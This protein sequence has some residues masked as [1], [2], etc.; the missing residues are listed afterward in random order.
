MSEAQDYRFIGQ[1]TIRPDGFDKVTGRASYGADL[2]LPGMIWGKVLRSPHAHAR[3]LRIDTSRAESHPDV[4]AVATHQDFPHVRSEAFQAGEGATDL[5]DLA[6][7]ILADKKVLYHGHA[8]AAVAARSESVALE[9]L[10]LIDVEYEVLTPVLDVED[11]MK[12]DAPLLHED[13]FTQGLAE[14]ATEPSNI[15]VRM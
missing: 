7:N 9:A 4:L 12:E 8:V 6:R 13:L 5:L 15:A 2:S 1:R 3:I 10:S 14:P 11:A